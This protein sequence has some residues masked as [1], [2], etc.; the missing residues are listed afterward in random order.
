VYALDEALDDPHNRYRH[1]VVEVEH[2]T[3]GRVPQ[4]GIGTK[5][6]ET[7]GRVRSPAPLPGQHTDEL[8]SSL[9]YSVEEIAGLREKGAVV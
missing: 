7:P 3:V 8:L 1:M 9:G 4:V 2:P 5:L 6:S